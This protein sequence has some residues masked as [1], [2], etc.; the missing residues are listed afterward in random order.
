[1]T[2]IGTARTTAVRDSCFRYEECGPRDRIL[3]SFSASATASERSA[4]IRSATVF[5][6]VGPKPSM[7]CKVRSCIAPGLAAMVLA[8]AARFSRSAE[9]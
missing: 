9:A 2:S 4:R 3:G 6:A 5:E 7:V 8:A 1:M